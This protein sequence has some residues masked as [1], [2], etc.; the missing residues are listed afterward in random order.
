MNVE[1]DQR[2][3][4]AAER[5][6]GVPCT[7]VTA[8]S[9]DDRRN[10]IL[11]ASTPSRSVII[12]ATRDKDYRR[13][14]RRSLRRGAGQGMGGDGISLPARAGQ[15]SGILR[16]RRRARPHRARGSRS[17]ASAA[18]RGPLARRF[19]RRRRTGAHR[20]RDGDRAAACRHAS[21]ASTATPIS[22]G[23][24]FRRR[25]G[26]AVQRR[27][28]A[29][30]G[31]RQGGGPAR[32]GTAGRRD[33]GHR[34]APVRSGP[35]ARPRPSRRL[36]GQC[37]AVGRPRASD[38]LR[39]RRAGPRAARR[40]LLAPGLSDLLV[41][42][43]RAGRRD[44]QRWIALIATRC[45]SRS[46][47]ARSGRRWRCCCSSAC[48]PARRG[49][50][51]ARCSEDVTWGISTNRPR[52]LWHLEA[53]IAGAEARARRPRRVARRR[54]DGATTSAGAGRTR[55]RSRSIRPSGSRRHVASTHPHPHANSGEVARQSTAT[56]HVTRT[57][58]PGR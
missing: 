50:W 25:S 3:I 29:P 24:I 33:R 54:C 49:C 42:G 18:W 45:R 46:T 47:T 9:D 8:L 35:V 30:R 27:S 51:S 53:T 10:L 12:K 13:A 6:L 2:A 14:G 57:E 22:C 11:R 39:I 44:R 43:A 40:H 28:V 5:D 55:S 17:R 16:R 21:A 41:R 20:L 52:L 36:P 31:G 37:A 48:S 15:R 1:Q 38:R 56:R 32:R 34:A 19:C 26:Q 4:A 58:L 23:A 7:H